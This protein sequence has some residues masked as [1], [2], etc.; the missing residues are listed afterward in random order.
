MQTAVT[1]KNPVT[2]RL[3]PPGEVDPFFG[4]NRSFYYTG[5]ERGYWKLI[6][7]LDDDIRDRPR[8]TIDKLGRRRAQR[9]RTLVPF[10]A[11]EKHLR[12]VIAKQEKEAS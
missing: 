1:K 12:R 5:E 9:G 6:R 4:L 2:F 7:I 3:P 10:D 11:V 8:K